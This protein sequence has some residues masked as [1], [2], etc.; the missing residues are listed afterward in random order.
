MNL[1]DH[2]WTLPL[3]WLSMKQ[4]AQMQWLKNK[5]MNKEVI[6][7]GD[8]AIQF[9]FLT[10]SDADITKSD[11]V[12]DPNCWRACCWRRAGGCVNIQHVLKSILVSREPQQ[13]QPRYDSKRFY[14]PSGTPPGS[15]ASL[16]YPGCIHSF[17]GA[18]V[19][20]KRT[21][22]L[23][24]TTGPTSESN[25]TSNNSS[26]NPGSPITIRDFRGIG[27]HT[28][29]IPKK[30]SQVSSEDASLDHPRMS[31]HHG[32]VLCLAKRRVTKFNIDRGTR[33]LWMKVRMV[34][35]YK[36]TM[37]M[38]RFSARIYCDCVCSFFFNIGQT[39][40][41]RRLLRLS[42]AWR[43]K[44]WGNSSSKCKEHGERKFI[45]Q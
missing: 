11:D 43:I 41:L 30:R 40:I 7:M 27:T 31:T 42:T 21:V 17:V 15:T 36:P 18:A 6:H 39:E 5:G 14:S 4:T 2:S 3:D 35:G 29:Q 22:T 32:G 13:D 24:L 37:R 38:R 8:F 1:A 19:D 45:F 9:Q 34:T 10:E 33:Y 26:F 25:L 20:F 12:T 28:S 44:S 23:V 16:W